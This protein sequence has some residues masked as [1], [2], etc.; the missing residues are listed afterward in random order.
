MIVIVS[1]ANENNLVSLF[2]RSI[3][4][5]FIIVIV[6]WGIGNDLVF[7]RSILVGAMIVIVFWSYPLVGL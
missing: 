1:W 2:L 4:I 7:F 5:G 6:S 3:L